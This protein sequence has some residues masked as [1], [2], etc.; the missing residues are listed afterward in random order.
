MPR[1]AFADACRGW[2]YDSAAMFCALGNGRPSLDAVFVV[3]AVKNA[4]F[5][6][7]CFVDQ[8][9]LFVANPTRGKDF[10]SLFCS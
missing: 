6:E 7:P 10:C 3:F 9:V 1:F 8:V 5:P 4:F 2:E